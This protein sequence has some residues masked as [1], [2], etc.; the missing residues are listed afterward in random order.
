MQKSRSLA[1]T[2]VAAPAQ[3]MAY[4]LSCFLVEYYVHLGKE[5]TEDAGVMHSVQHTLSGSRLTTWCFNLI[6]ETR[7]CS[8][9][10]NKAPRMGNI[11]L[12][13]LPDFADREKDIV[14]M[15]FGAW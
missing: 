13:H 9:R 10:A 4:G 3:D 11:I 7:I 2:S 1:L 14:I 5:I 15:N 8:L 12:R 6:Q